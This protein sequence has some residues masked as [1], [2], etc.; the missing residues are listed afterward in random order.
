MEDRD[1]RQNPNL[2]PNLNGNLDPRV[3]REINPR[4]NSNINPGVN[5][6]LN[7]RDADDDFLLR[8]NMSDDFVGAAVANAMDGLNAF[9][10]D[11]DWIG[12]LVRFDEPD[13]PD[14]DK[15]VDGIYISFDTGNNGTGIAV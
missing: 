10:Q 15:L 6:N 11:N 2:N 1:P 9:N 14:E 4:V 3:N 7:P 8:F 12:L 5:T 13:D